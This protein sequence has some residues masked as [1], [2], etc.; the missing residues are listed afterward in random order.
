MRSP[1]LTARACQIAA[2]VGLAFSF[3]VCAAPA[4]VGSQAFRSSYSVD[5]IESAATTPTLARGERGAAVVRAQVLLDRAWYSC[6]EIDGAFGDNMRK[7][8]AAF[9]SAHGREPTGRIDAD[10]WQALQADD[11]PILTRYTVTDRDANGPF[12]RIPAPIMER[13][14]LR[15]LGYENIVEELAESFHVSPRLLRALN[16]GKPF[17]AG[18]EIVVPDVVPAKTVG[19]AASI[20]VFKEDRR[21]QALDRAGR[22][23][24]QFPISLGGPRDPLPVG[25]LKIA[26]EVKN[27]V[28]N[29]DPALLGDANPEHRKIKIA[30]GPNNP[31]GV[32]WLGLSKRH[33][34]IHGTPEPAM[35][36][37]METHGCLH[38][39]NWDGLKLASIVSPGVV[40]DVRE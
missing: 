2:F 38:L 30:P 32:V 20:V 9:Q 39:T 7:A 15:W 17:V 23:L 35:V 3:A 21:L 31:V 14:E 36:G 25:K 1:T 13:A 6:G 8:V 18:A 28:F 19:K 34:G 29:Y 26:N 24:A 12:T 22:V 10:T 37:R 16:P 40:V 4:E 33:W 5:A 11:A 27:P